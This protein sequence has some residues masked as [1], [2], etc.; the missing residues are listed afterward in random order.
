MPASLRGMDSLFPDT[1][2]G[3]YHPIGLALPADSCRPLTQKAEAVQEEDPQPSERISTGRK[4]PSLLL[5]FEVVQFR[6]LWL[7]IF[8][9]SMSM[10]IR[11]LSQGWLVLELTDSPFW[12]GLIAGLQGIGLV[13]FGALAGTIVDR[14]DKRKVLAAAH[15]GSGAAA[16]AVGVLFVTD[17]LELWHLIVAALMQG[18]VMATQLPA[19]N[20]LAYQI[21][22]PSR[23]LNAMATRLAGMN[24]TRI[25]GSLIAGALIE[26]YGAGSSYLFAG[27]CSLVG[28]SLL[29]FI[30]GNFRSSTEREPFWRSVS[31]GIQYSWRSADIRRLLLLSLIMEA[32][33]FSHFV[34]MPVIARDVLHVGAQG[35]G[36]LSAASGAGSALSTILVSSLGDFKDKGKLL[37]G[38]AFGAGVTLSVFA[39]STWFPASLVLVAMVGGCLMAYDVT[40]GTMLQ[41]LSLDEMRGRV[42]GIYGLTFGFTP[43]GGFFVGAV[44]TALTA[45]IA[46]AMGGAF[47]ILYVAAIARS[48]LR[49][50]PRS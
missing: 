15:L 16:I 35:L 45:S 24:F 41:L 30:K 31:Q 5:S 42:L 43:V 7:S 33:G 23:L 40:M 21:V 50:S 34:M 6:W 8:F 32:F 29:W 36:Y 2:N 19:S 25:I 46:V 4:L 20:S 22:G 44:A 17:K 28:V 27:G 3:V 38:T 12:V 48:A 47:I 26:R 9:S 18:I 37:V 11:M 39:F 10:G 13:G 49:I 1:G 14:F